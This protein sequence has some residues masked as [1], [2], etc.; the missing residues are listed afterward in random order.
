[1]HRE[2]LNGDH[3]NQVVD[4]LKIGM[5]LFIGREVLFF[6]AWFWAFFH[7]RL[8]PV[9]EI[10]LAWPPVGLSPLNPFRIPLLNTAILLSSGVRVT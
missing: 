9:L 2:G 1:V 5:V 4:G 7:H 8:V 10:G 6:L 3:T